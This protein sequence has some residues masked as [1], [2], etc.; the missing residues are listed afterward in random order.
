[1][2]YTSAAVRNLNNNAVAFVFETYCGSRAPRVTVDIGQTFLND[3]KKRE[4]S[5][6]GQPYKIRRDF[7][8]HLDVAAFRESVH[9]PLKRRRQ[10]C[11]LKKRRMKKIR[12]SANL[13]GSLFQQ[14]SIF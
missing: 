5:V 8:I 12:N 14:A 4:L 7:Q 11:N 10:T 9:V 13:P 6:L 2:G 3:S 1:M